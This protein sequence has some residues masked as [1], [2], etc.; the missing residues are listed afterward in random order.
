GTVTQGGELSPP[1]GFVARSILPTDGPDPNARRDDAKKQREEDKL[2]KTHVPWWPKSADG[3]WYWKSD[4]SS[5]ELD[6]HYFFYAAYY[7]L[8]ADTEEERA[9]VREHVLALTDHLIEHDFDLV[10][11]DGKPTRWARYNPKTWDDVA[12]WWAGRGLNS[13]SILSY[14]KT[15]EHISGGDKKYADAY[16]YLVTEH[17]YAANA[18]VP[19]WQM[20]PGCGNQ[21]DD[22]MGFMCFYNLM[23]YENDPQRKQN[24]AFAFYNYW[25]IEEP[26]MNPLFNFMYASQGWGL[27]HVNPF[28]TTDLTPTGPWLEDSLDALR[29]YPVD[30]I[31]WSIKNSHRKDIVPLAIHAREQNGSQ[32]RGHLPSGYVLPIDERNL[33]HWSQDVWELDYGGSGRQLNDPA[34]Y[35]LAYYMGLYHGFIV[36][37]E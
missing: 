1:K 9:R 8:V 7:D 31:E 3:K 30:R 37:T 35:L 10:D 36:E 27:E 21:S 24:Y 14:L 28:G 2:W 33:E 34:A 13:V 29:R 32:G 18:M 17:Q 20:C 12:A 5:D 16:N 23:K 19:K 4:T 11:Y 22:E 6:G 25:R 26:E 15:A